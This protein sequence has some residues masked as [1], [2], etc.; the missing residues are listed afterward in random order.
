MLWLGILNENVGPTS[1]LLAIE[2]NDEQNSSELFRTNGL[3]RMFPKQKLRAKATW[4]RSR[5]R[6]TAVRLG[7]RRHFLREH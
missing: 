2:D 1:S 7:Y 5:G 3:Q 4:G 6:N